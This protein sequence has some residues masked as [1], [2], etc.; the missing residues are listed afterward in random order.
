MVLNLRV[1]GHLLA[2]LQRHVRLF[3]IRTVAGESSPA[4]QLAHLVGG[5]NAV[6][7]HLEQ[8][9]HRR[10]HHHLIG[11][12]RHLETQRALVF[13]L[14]DAFLGHHRSFNTFVDGHFASA[15]E[16]CFAA[17]SNTRTLSATSSCVSTARMPLAL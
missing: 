10:L 1:L 11:F 9:L 3:P 5:P 4:P 16:S 6:H 2:L 17:S 14:G 13:F 8:L 12:R 15:S 7:F